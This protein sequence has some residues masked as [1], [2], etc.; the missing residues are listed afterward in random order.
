MLEDEGVHIEFM[1][2]S[3]EQLW[4][5]MEQNLELEKLKQAQREMRELRERHARE[6]QELQERHA[7]GIPVQELDSIRAL[8]TLMEDLFGQTDRALFISDLNQ[9]IVNLVSTGTVA[10]IA[11]A[12]A[13][14]RK[15]R[16]NSKVEIEDE[17]KAKESQP[18]QVTVKK[19]YRRSEPRENTKPGSKD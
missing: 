5:S 2:P 9:I 18:T 10:A 19:R 1:E 8:P 14:F 13:K 7:R 6:L 12:V 11:T 4:Q 17:A 15:R 3:L 16:P